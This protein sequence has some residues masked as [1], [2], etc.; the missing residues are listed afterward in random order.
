MPHKLVYFDTNIYAIVKNH[1]RDKTSDYN[2]IKRGIE[3]GFIMIP[4]SI[5]V[6]EEALPIYRSESLKVLAL[7]KQTYSEIMN[8]RVFIKY[9][10]ELLR[11]EIMAHVNNRQ[12]APFTN[13]YTLTPDDWFTTD[14]KQSNAWAGLDPM[15]EA[16]KNKFADGQKIIR[17]TYEQNIQ[18]IP[19]RERKQVTVSELWEA[20]AKNR[21]KEYASSYG[22]D[23]L[24]EPQIEGLL[25][26]RSLGAVIRYDVAYLYKKLILGERIGASDSRDHHHVA[27]SAV[28]DIFVTEDKRFAALLG[29]IPIQNR[30]VWSYK[31]FIKWLSKA[32]AGWQAAGLQ[33][34]DSYYARPWSEK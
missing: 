6:L 9:H 21:A 16:E 1:L 19:K 32:L 22:L 27:L 8:W 33:M 15:I 11:D 29:L 31:Q 34:P 25:N 20:Y 5:A 7:E 26:L 23:N 12:F 13:S 17:Q 24:S 2:L 28:T 4:G 3:L 10:A 14:R 18:Q 30:T